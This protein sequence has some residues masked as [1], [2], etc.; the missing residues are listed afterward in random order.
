MKPAQ[1]KTLCLIGS[2][3]I[4]ARYGGFEYFVQCL[5]DIND[6]FKNL[7][8]IVFCQS[9]LKV[10]PL[11]YKYTSRIFVDF[12]ANG[13]QSLIYD[14]ISLLIA[15]FKADIILLL[16]T[17]T[18][19]FLPIFKL[20]FFKNKYIVHYDGLEWRRDKWKH[21]NPLHPKSMAKYIYYISSVFSD[22]CA[23]L[24]IS[25]N[26]GITD[27][28]VNKR[29]VSS[30]KIVEIGYSSNPD[31]NIGEVTHSSDH[32]TF[33]AISKGTIHINPHL[34]AFGICRIEPDNSVHTILEAY[35][36]FL[37]N[38]SPHNI[39]Y[40]VFVGN[41]SSSS[42]GLGLIKKYSKRQEFFLVDSCYDEKILTP[43]R[44][45]CSL[46]IHGHKHGGTNPSLIQAMDQ[47]KFISIHHNI[48]NISTMKNS[49]TFSWTTLDDIV[50]SFEK[51]DDYLS[52][53]ESSSLEVLNFR[54]SIIPSWK[55]IYDLV[56]EMT[57]NIC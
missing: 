56:C 47:S 15:S 20:I 44:R 30:K 49:Q 7:R 48:Y 10:V 5:C 27:F 51:H 2:A 43:L 28:L 41:F 39:K 52:L 21:K 13:F 35:D 9:S 31:L 24:I 1:Q 45:N 55:S 54:Q 8:L 17:S 32:V 16:G 37:E 26:K 12:N 36:K 53:S 57:S 11:S 6:V 19:F 34:C 38:R 46:Y 22:K 18:S 4:P 50:D 25:D 40:L 42:Y 33:E 14:F 23:D 29:N 3:G